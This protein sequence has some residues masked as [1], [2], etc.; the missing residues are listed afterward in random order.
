[1]FKSSWNRNTQTDLKISHDIL[2]HLKGK[3][4]FWIKKI[5]FFKFSKFIFK[6]PTGN[7][8]EIR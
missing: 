1:M 6:K 2:G 5:S 8:K 4:N 3:S 7:N